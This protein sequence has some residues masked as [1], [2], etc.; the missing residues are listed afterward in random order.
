MPSLYRYGRA[1]IEVEIN[2]IAINEVRKM[3]ISRTQQ[4]PIRHR[5]EKQQLIFSHF[6][7]FNIDIEN[8]TY[9]TGLRHSG[10]TPQEMYQTN[11]ALKKIHDDYFEA[12]KHAHQKYI[13]K[14]NKNE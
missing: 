6:S 8:D 2:A 3:S 14:V 11:N 12:I 9:T 13:M 1:R 5:N 4:P 7:D 10:F